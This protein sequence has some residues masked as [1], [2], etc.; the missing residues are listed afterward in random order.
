M[1]TKETKEFAKKWV[2]DGNPCLYGR[3]WHYRGGVE[4]T[5]TKEKAVELLPSY[6]FGMGFHELSFVKRDGK[7]C[8]LFNELSEND[9]W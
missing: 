8:L 5:I 1:E 7:T 3:G 2:E 4:R 9:L 6:S